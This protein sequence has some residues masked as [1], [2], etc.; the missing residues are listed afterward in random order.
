MCL[1]SQSKFCFFFRFL[2]KVW[3]AC[4]FWWLI[5]CLIKRRGWWRIALSKTHVSDSLETTS[6]DHPSQYFELRM[7]L[8]HFYGKS[9]AEIVVYEG[10]SPD[11]LYHTLWTQDGLRL[12]VYDSH[13]RFKLQPY[14]SNILSNTLD[15][16]DE[17]NRG[18][19]KEQAKVLVHPCILTPV[20]Q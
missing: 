18:I 13:L 10:V 1:Q 14:L 17:I 12:T 19:T 6:S 15:V 16:R 3:S 11:G 2:F 9:K 8:S 4:Y 5:F 7:I 20:H